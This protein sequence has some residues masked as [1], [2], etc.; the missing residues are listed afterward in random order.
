M[1]V[2]NLD[3]WSSFYLLDEDKAR[4]LMWDP[5]PVTKRGNHRN[6]E[7]S[8]AAQK[9]VKQRNNTSP[10][11]FLDPVVLLPA[12]GNISGVQGGCHGFPL[13]SIRSPS[14]PPAKV[15]LWM[16]PKSQVMVLKGRHAEPLEQFLKKTKP[17][18]WV[19]PDHYGLWK[20][21]VYE[22]VQM[23]KGETWAS[24]V[25]PIPGHLLEEVYQRWW[26]VNGPFRFLDLP[27]EIRNM[28]LLFS[29]ETGYP[30]WSTSVEDV[31]SD[32]YGET[33]ATSVLP[34]TL[35]LVN[36]QVSHEAMGLMFARTRVS[37]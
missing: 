12:C 13:Y 9:V 4:K 30:K 31:R 36:K 14:S 19:L 3:L 37:W 25:Y 20:R 22:E 10:D 35:Y 28:I 27:G 34:M 17:I 16:S 24:D 18:P 21:I 8:R 2:P 26:S 23:E 32:C 15:H 33:M 5:W 29:L 7:I 11:T 1:V 6:D